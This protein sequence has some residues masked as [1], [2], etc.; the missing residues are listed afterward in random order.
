[1]STEYFLDTN[2]V[3]YAVSDDA[4]KAD[5]SE[6]LL[7]GGATISIQVLNETA[8]TLRRRFSATW[9]KIADISRRVRKACKVLPLTEAIHE[10]GLAIAARHRLHVYDSMLVAAALTAGCKTLYSED[11]HNGLRIE[12]LTIRNPYA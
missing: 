3:V 7:V 9:P 5:R 6:E 8:L 1:M 10:S 4:R 11:M 12:G 2:V